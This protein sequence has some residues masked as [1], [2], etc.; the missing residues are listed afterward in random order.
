VQDE[1]AVFSQRGHF[2]LMTDHL[3]QKGRTFKQPLDMKI[4]VASGAVTVQYTDDHGQPKHDVEHIELPDDL[5]NGLIITLL[6]NVQPTALP[7]SVG[8]IAATPKPRLVKLEL[9][10][11][12][13]DTFKLAGITR[14]ATHF[15]LKV[16]VGGLT[17][18]VADWLGKVP[19]DSL[20][21]VLEGDAPTFVR[22]ETPLFMGGPVVRTELVSPVWR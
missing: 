9:N 20:V 8:Y 21:W 11:A 12:G 6:K 4:D 13:S 3:I 19:P 5:A 14:R 17:G 2:K 15:V 18:V 22:S 7:P 10:V 1:T 16:K